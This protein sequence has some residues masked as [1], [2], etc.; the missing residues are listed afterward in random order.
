MKI[1]SLIPARGNSKRIKL[2]N[3]VKIK[4]KPLLQYSI[5]SSLKSKLI[6]KSFVSTESLKIKTFCTKFN[7]NIH[8]RPKN[9][10]KDTSSTEEV[11]NNF[12]RQFNKNEKPDIIVLL[13][14]TSLFRNN[15]DIDMALK[16]FIK[17]KYDSLFSVCLNTKLFWK[18]TLNTYKPINY[19]L[20]YRKREQDM[21]NQYQ[22]N[23]SIYIFKVK[24]YKGCRLFGKIG[25]YEMDE[26]RSIQID[27]KYDLIL[28]NKI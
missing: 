15:N 28:A 9:L 6:D 18:K 20:R 3:L 11:I 16:K 22:E 24:R 10:S 26:K 23:G 4:K 12:I 17:N 14:P 27:T 25:I 5:E 8:N 13:Q 7:I 2:K 19:N 1:Y 21:K